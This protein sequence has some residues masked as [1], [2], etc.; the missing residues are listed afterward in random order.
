MKTGSYKDSVKRQFLP[1]CPPPLFF[2]TTF[3]LNAGSSISVAAVTGQDNGSRKRIASSSG[4]NAFREHA[5]NRCSG[6]GGEGGG[7]S[8]HLRTLDTLLLLISRLLLL[9][10]T[11]AG[12]KL[13]TRLEQRATEAAQMKDAVSSSITAGQQ[14][15]RKS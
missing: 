7:R 8:H 13:Q 12:R 14:L 2:F 6:G 11:N 15:H 10:I 9:L 4:A 5:S 1:L 3:P